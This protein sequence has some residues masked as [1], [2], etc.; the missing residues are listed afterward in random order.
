[1]HFPLEDCRHLKRI[2]RI[3]NEST[4]NATISR[5]FINIVDFVLALFRKKTAEDND[6]DLF[7][8][9]DQH[10]IPYEDI[11]IVSVPSRNPITRK[12]YEAWNIIW[13]VVF[14]ESMT[15]KYLI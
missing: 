9:L 1:M 15:E 11:S 13:P 12:Q 7:S 10:S 2:R 14:H 6:L 3:K 5:I 4:L 8:N